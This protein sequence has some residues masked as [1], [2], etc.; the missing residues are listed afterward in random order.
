MTVPVRPAMLEHEDSNQVDL[1]RGEVTV[2]SADI[3]NLLMQISG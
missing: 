2:V 3:V 1:R